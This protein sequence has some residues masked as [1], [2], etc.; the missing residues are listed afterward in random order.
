[1]ERCIIRL[2]AYRAMF[3]SCDIKLDDDDDDDDF[4]Q[5][6]AYLSL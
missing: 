3:V 1:M 2:I 5:T 4:W 6:I